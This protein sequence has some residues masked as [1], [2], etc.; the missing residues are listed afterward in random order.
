MSRLV[1]PEAWGLQRVTAREV[2]EAGQSAGFRVVIEDGPDNGFG[3]Q[4]RLKILDSYRAGEFV[5]QSAADIPLFDTDRQRLAAWAN[6]TGYLVVEFADN[7]KVVAPK[8]VN[9]PTSNR[10]H[11]EHT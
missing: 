8:L 7:R 9:I 3:T 6:E 5:R 1:D 10:P 11:N 2:V 4:Y